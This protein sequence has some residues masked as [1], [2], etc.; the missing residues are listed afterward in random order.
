MITGS[1]CLKSIFGRKRGK[2]GPAAC[3][4]PTANNAIANAIASST[5]REGEPV[6]FPHE[7]TTFSSYEE[8]KK[9]YNLY[10]WEVRF[11]IRESRSKTNA[12]NYTTRKETLFAPVRYGLNFVLFKPEVTDLQRKLNDVMIHCW[13]SRDSAE[14][15]EHLRQGRVAKQ[16]CGSTGWKTIHG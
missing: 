8:A 15:Q 16:C 13:R 14:T 7:G 4:A 10:S 5:Q 9:F 11:G 1:D 6:F 12:N 3:L 2:E